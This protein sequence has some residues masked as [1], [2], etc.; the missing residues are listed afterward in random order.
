MNFTRYT[1]L[2]PESIHLNLQ[3]HNVEGFSSFV[4]DALCEQVAQKDIRARAIP[5]FSSLWMGQVAHH[6]WLLSKLKSQLLPSVIFSCHSL[7]SSSPL[8]ASCILNLNS[9]SWHMISW[10]SERLIQTRPTGRLSG[11]VVQRTWFL[12]RNCL[13]LLYKNIWYCCHWHGW[14]M[15]Q[16][17]SRNTS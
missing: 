3:Y 17:L 6:L 7:L 8:H 2:W 10:Y 12:A 11:Y 9:A 16:R 13:D 5:F 1:H 4:S 14:E 15:S